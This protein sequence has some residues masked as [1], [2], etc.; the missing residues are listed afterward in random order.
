MQTKNLITSVILF[1]GIV[2]ISNGQPGINYFELRSGNDIQTVCENSPISMI[3]YDFFLPEPASVSGLPPGVTWS[4]LSGLLTISGTPISAGTYNYVV[5]NAGQ[6]TGV[7]TVTA[8]TTPTFS[9]LPP[10]NSGDTLAALLT[11]SINGITGVWY[12]APN[13]KATTTYTFTPT[14]GLCVNTATMTI[15]VISACTQ[16]I[17]SSS[18]PTS[19]SANTVVQL[20]GNGFL[21]GTGTTSVKFNGIEASSFAIISN[22]LLE[23]VVP[24]TATIGLISITTNNCIGLSAAP[25]SIINSTSNN[26]YSFD[27]YISEIYDAYQGSGAIIEIYNGTTV[28]KDLTNYTFER[29]SDIGDSGPN[30]TLPLSGILQ[31]GQFYLIGVDGFQTFPCGITPNLAYSVGINGNDEFKL[32]NSGVLIDDVQA[33]NE[34]GYTINRSLTA[35]AP[36]PV[37]NIADWT[38]SS[39]ESCADIGLH[40]PTTINPTASVNPSKVT[41]CEKESTTFTATLDSGLIYN[42]QWKV[43]KTDNTWVNVVNNTNYS[44]ATSYILSINNAPASFNKNQYYCELN[45]AQFSIVSN[46]TQLK[47]NNSS[48]IPIFTPVAAVCSGTTIA[49]LPTTSN[50]GITGIWSPELN[51]TTT[52]TYTFTPTAGQCAATTTQTITV[53][54]TKVTSPI[55]FEAPVATLSSVTIGTQ[56]WTNKNLDVTTYRDGT[57]IPEVT[58]PVAW[59]ALTTGAWCY[60]NNDPANGAIYGKLYNWYA[61]AGIHDN[62]PN[63]P[64][65]ILAPLGYHVPS[66][67]EWTTLTDYLGGLTVAGGKMKERGTT[68]WISPNTPA[69]NESGFIGLPGGYM[70]SNSG[71]STIGYIGYWWSSSQNFIDPSIQSN[72]WNRWLGGAGG[73]VTR[74]YGNLKYGKSVRCIKD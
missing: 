14:A 30:Y 62:D 2:F 41:I 18:F 46:A 45:N 47:L 26:T 69:S 32:Y 67:S 13:N 50:N 12:P 27:I 70:N 58:D 22:T 28:A 64:N 19:G 17:I 37:F 54:T 65:K 72:A 52:T 8:K 53:T 63:T 11:T 40:S 48:A 49:A 20:N 74:I 34:T 73:E 36:K 43:L 21:V 4:I 51:N 25:F 16:P 44:G 33:P 3:T 31:P 23:A 71:F 57:P 59:A 5:N 9:Q 38:I 1:L 61:V 60:Y 7:I 39:T 35:I 68:H 15:N 42:Y 66:D 10:I 55:S 6:L 29:Y 24:T 56:I